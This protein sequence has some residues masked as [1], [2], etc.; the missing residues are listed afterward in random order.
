MGYLGSRANTEKNLGADYEQLLIAVFHVFMGLNFFLK[1]F[2]LPL[3]RLILKFS[4]LS[5]VHKGLL[6]QDWV[7]NSDEFELKFP[8]LSQ[9]ELKM[10]RAEFEHWLFLSRFLN[11]SKNCRP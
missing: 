4:N 5:V 7:F 3:N 2:F 9:A 6:M 1:T 8:K 11:F 10:L